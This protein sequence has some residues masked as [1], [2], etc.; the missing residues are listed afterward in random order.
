MP[1]CRVCSAPLPARP[2]D[3]TLDAAKAR[4]KAL[5]ALLAKQPALLART[6]PPV[7]RHMKALLATLDTN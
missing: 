7:R 3:P 4:A 1:A 5:A 2:A 6:P